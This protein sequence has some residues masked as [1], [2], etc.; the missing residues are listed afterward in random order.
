RVERR[1]LDAVEA[2]LVLRR[3]TRPREDRLDAAVLCYAQHD[4]MS[5]PR[6]RELHLARRDGRD[7]RPVRVGRAE[8]GHAAPRRL[9]PRQTPPPR[10]PGEQPDDY[11]R[12]SCH[13]A[14]PVGAETYLLSLRC[15]PPL[16]CLTAR[17][18]VR[19]L[20]AMTKCGTV[21]PAGRPNVGRST[22][23]NAVIGEHLAIVSPKPQSTR[24]PVVGLLTRGDTQFIFTDSPGLLEPEYRL[25]E[26][27]RAAAL[28][29]I[30]AAEVIAYLHPLSEYPA[31][32][33]EQLAR[34]DRQPKS[35]IV[36]V[37]TKADVVPP[38]DRPTVRLSDGVVVAA[39]RGDGLDALLEALRA[40]VPDGPFHYDPDEIATQPMRFFAAEFVREAAFELLHDELP[41]SVAVEID[42]FREGSEPVYIRAVVYVER[43]SQKGIVIG[44]GGRTIK[45]LGA[46]ARAKIAALLDGSVYLDLHVKVLPRWRRHA[47]SLKRLGYAG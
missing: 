28:R 34:L 32:P 4:D 27:M 9:A 21:V 25:H 15:A 44:E 5:R 8:P 30:E 47:P 6:Q 7:A 20:T 16:R 40:R 41:Y 26:A 19:C 14:P 24:L 2:G 42:E 1:A 39:V 23:L 11:Q 46:A 3:L 45:A 13:L 38:S 12:S 43:D 33:L 37:Y 29:A 18:P 35:P 22:L 17:R 31:P 36:T 10:V